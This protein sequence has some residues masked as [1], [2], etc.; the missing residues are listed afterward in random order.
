MPVDY[1]STATEVSNDLVGVLVDTEISAPTN[2]GIYILS[3]VDDV[4][5]FYKI[6]GK[7]TILANKAY[8]KVNDTNAKYFSLDGTATAIEQ[9]LVAPLLDK[10]APVYNLQGQ[11]VARPAHGIFIQNG[12]KFVVK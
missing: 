6:S 2:G 3:K 10:N 4:F 12:K 8:L 7:G 9:A 5:G 1:T 11:R